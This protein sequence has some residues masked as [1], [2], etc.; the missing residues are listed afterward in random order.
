MQVP[1]EDAPP[2]YANLAIAL[3]RRIEKQDLKRSQFEDIMRILRGSSED[4]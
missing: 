1:L 2:E 4:E 3:A